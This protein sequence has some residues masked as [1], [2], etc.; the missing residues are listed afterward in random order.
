[1]I[2]YKLSESF[3]ESFYNY[4]QGRL[5]VMHDGAAIMLATPTKP[6]VFC[7]NYIFSVLKS[8]NKFQE[9]ELDKETWVHP[10]L[11]KPIKQLIENAHG[12]T[13]TN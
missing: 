8:G 7:G 2:A 10:H 9:I 5:F 13:T 4:E 3:K 12:P 1:M 6:T 11:Y